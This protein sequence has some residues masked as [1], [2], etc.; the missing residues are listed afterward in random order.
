MGVISTLAT[1]NYQ[2]VADL[3]RKTAA[4]RGKH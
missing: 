3:L 4:R 1:L 2:V